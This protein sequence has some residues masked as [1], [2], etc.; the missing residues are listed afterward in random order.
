M[1]IVAK[2]FDIKIIDKII[3]YNDLCVDKREKIEK[4]AYLINDLRSST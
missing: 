4:R 2:V 3:S 1:V